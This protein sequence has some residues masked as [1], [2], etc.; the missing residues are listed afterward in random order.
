[1]RRDPAGHLKQKAEDWDSVAVSGEAWG[2]G[3]PSEW[4]EP[5]GPGPGPTFL[6]HC[7][8]GA[9][10]LR[11]APLSSMLCP[12]RKGLDPEGVSQRLLEAGPK[13]RAPGQREASLTAPLQP[14]C[15]D[16]QM[17]VALTRLFIDASSGLFPNGASVSQRPGNTPN[18]FPW[19][20]EGEILWELRLGREKKQ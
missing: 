16:W 14:G 11:M 9:S 4:R 2:P 19:R 3:L 1:M 10:W 5:A 18:A 12:H 15:T 20:Q 6:C 17:Q 8:F 7:T 13:A